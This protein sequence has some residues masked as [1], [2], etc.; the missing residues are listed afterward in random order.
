MPAVAGAISGIVPSRWVFEGL[1]LL[2]ADQR[3]PGRL[4]AQ[5]DPDI[6]HDLAAAYFPAAERM[7]E[8]ADRMA[9]AAMLVGLAAAVAFIVASAKPSLRTTPTHPGAAMRPY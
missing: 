1:V 8:R 9:L 3:E 5:D 4:A 6:G 2:E 7:G